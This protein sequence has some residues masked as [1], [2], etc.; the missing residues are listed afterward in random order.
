VTSMI[1]GHRTVLPA[2]QPRGHEASGVRR[3]P[4]H[5]HRYMYLLGRW[6]SV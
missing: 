2:K 4:S 1:V 3:L 5:Q 6:S